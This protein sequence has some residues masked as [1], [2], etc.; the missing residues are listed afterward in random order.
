MITHLTM[1]LFVINGFVSGVIFDVVIMK[2][3][4]LFSS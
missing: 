3:M 2:R 4:T 1:N